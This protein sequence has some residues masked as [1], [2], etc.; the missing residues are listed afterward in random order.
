MGLIAKLHKWDDTAIFFEGTSLGTSLPFLRGVRI[1]SRIFLSLA[2]YV[3]A[4]GVYLTV[5][6]PSLRTIVDPVAGVDTRE[7]RIEAMRILAAGN[8]IIMVLLG[9]VLFLQVSTEYFPHF[10]Q[11]AFPILGLAW[12]VSSGSWKNWRA[13]LFSLIPLTEKLCFRN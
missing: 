11:P 2:A 1:S 12:R 7:D 6:I 10:T 3:F 9:A 5:S 8:T 13:Y 4:V